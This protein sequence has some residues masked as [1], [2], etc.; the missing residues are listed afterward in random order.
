MPLMMAASWIPFA[1]CGAS[2]VDTRVI[3]QVALCGAG[4]A[5]VGWVLHGEFAGDDEG[6]DLLRAPSLEGLGVEVDAAESDVGVVGV[7]VFGEV[8]FP[9][10]AG[11]V[12]CLAPEDEDVWCAPGEVVDGAVEVFRRGP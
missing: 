2:T 5:A 12:V 7:D 4:D 11:G 8:V 3:L 9:A 10:G 6:A 1:G